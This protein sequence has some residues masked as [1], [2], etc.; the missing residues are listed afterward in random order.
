MARVIV[1]SMTDQ[2]LQIVQEATCREEMTT[3]VA[4]VTTATTIVEIRETTTMTIEEE[5]AIREE[6]EDTDLIHMTQGVP[7]PVEI[8][9]EMAVTRTAEE[10]HIMEATLLTTTSL[11]VLVADLAPEIEILFLRCIWILIK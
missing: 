8:N 6:G 4:I 2:A 10:V 1:T 3:V 5:I 7:A 9:A 11:M